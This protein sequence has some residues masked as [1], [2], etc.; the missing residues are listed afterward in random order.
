MNAPLTPGCDCPPWSA[1]VLDHLQLGLLVLD[2]EQ[3]VVFANRWFLQHTGLTA[4]ALLQRQ[5]DEVFEQLKGSAFLYSLTQ[6]VAS[7]FPTLLSQT[8]HPAPFPL[9][10]SAA[11]RDQDKLLRQSIRIIPAGLSQVGSMD[12]RYTFIQ[13]TDVTQSVMRERLLKAQASKLK[14]LAN[15][16]VLTGLGNRRLLDDSLP[17]LVRLVGKQGAALSLVMFDIDYFKQFNDTYGHLAGD[18]CLRQVAGVLRQV[19]RRPAD[20]VVRFGGEELVAVL[21]ETELDDALA[22]ANQ[23]LQQV[24][25]LAIV[26]AGS[27]VAKVVTLSAGVAVLQPGTASTPMNL[28]Q[29]VDQVMYAAKS[30]GR[31]QVCWQPEAQ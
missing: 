23:V 31:N 13:I 24:R 14:A 11:Q 28:L 18:D 6:A 30:A 29:Q 25:D 26:N 2:A 1:W 21:P 15:V 20:L 5:L 19:F 9:Y 8:L 22:L 27:R 10:L 12:Q 17:Q 7:G 3:R 4:P 16:D